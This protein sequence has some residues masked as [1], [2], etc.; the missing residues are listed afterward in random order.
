[1]FKFRKLPPIKT[2]FQNLLVNLRR[3]SFFKNLLIVMSGTA[4]AQLISYALSPIISRL[5]SPEH[6][7]VFGSF[8]AIASI[9]GALITL[10]YSQAI[11][12]PKENRDAINLYSLSITSTLFISLLVLAF[13]VVETPT[14]HSL[15]KTK[16]TWPLVLLMLTVIVTGINQASQAWAVR[17]KEFK[18]TSTSQVIRSIFSGGTRIVFGIF[19]T[20]AIGL[21]ISNIIANIMASINLICVVVPDL[22]TLRDSITL[23]KMKT[24][25]KEYIDFPLYSA[26]QNFINAISSGLPILLLTKF[27]TIAVAG[28]YAFG[29]NILSA[30]MSL[31]LAGLRQVLFQRACEAQHQG[32]NLASLYIKT[33]GVLFTIAL[34]PTLILIIWAPQIFSFIFGAKWHLSGI[35]ARS[36]IIWLAVAF[37]NLPAVLFARIIRIQ[38]FVFFYDLVLLAARTLTLV[39]GGM[40]FKVTHTVMAFAVVGALMNAFLIFYVGQA[41]SKKD[42]INMQLIFQDFFRA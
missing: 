21:I 1:M 39:I 34:F 33:T 41:I 3:S 23:K 22:L 37:C 29:V 5:F 18:K 13:I 24:L 36:L 31:V 42:R 32:R 11:M 14:V 15:T 10:D 28:A 16:G 7:G 2:I 25:A 8:Y 27:Y 20:G 30:P 17:S 4:V 6:F 35:L 38:R 40:Y 19:K 26:S 9:I 12:L